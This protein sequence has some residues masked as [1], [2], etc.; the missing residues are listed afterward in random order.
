MEARL[1]TQNARY[2]WAFCTQAGTV[3]IHPHL[4]FHF[5]CH[6][7]PV[8]QVYLPVLPNQDA[9]AQMYLESSRTWHTVGAQQGDTD[10]HLPRVTV[11][12]RESN[13]H[14]DGPGHSGP[15]FTLSLP[16]CSGQEPGRPSSGMGLAPGKRFQ[17]PQ[18]A[19]P[20]E[21]CP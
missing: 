7:N 18:K 13:A 21:I 8:E 9:Q 10:R 12:R 5:M 4:L 15:H 20:R 16:A 2:W 3:G 19:F 11:R 1:Q 6:N 14:S 17:I